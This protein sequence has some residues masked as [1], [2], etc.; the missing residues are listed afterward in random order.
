LPNG[1]NMWKGIGNTV[2]L[3]FS[4][5]RLMEYIMVLPEVKDS[6]VIV[7]RSD[8]RVATTSRRITSKEINLDIVTWNVRTL[9][10]AERLENLTSEMDKCELKAVGL[11][12]VRWPGNSEMVS[13]NYTMFYSGG[14]KTEKGVAVVLRN[15]VV[16]CLTKVECCSD[17]LMFVKCEKPVGIVLV[18]VYMPTTNHNDDE[19]EKLYEEM[20]EI[21]QQ[22]GRGQVNAIVMGDFN[23]IVGEE[24][25]DKVVIPFGVGR[26]N[27]RGKMLMTSAS[28]M[29]S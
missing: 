6:G 18:Q 28:N 2:T 8:L 15:H 17:R 4:L 1:M 7:Q 10:Q 19:K 24:S 22:E 21:L 29:I 13:G 25:T 16:K 9:R 14:V 23:S 5:N 3:L 20:G 27:E 11:S 12:E 26:K